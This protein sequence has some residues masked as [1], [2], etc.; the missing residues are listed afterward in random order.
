MESKLIDTP[1]FQ[2][3]R[4]ISQLG[5]VNYVFPSAEHTR[6]SH[7]L[8]VLSMMDRIL[9]NIS[10][11]GFELPPIEIEKLRLAALLHDIGHYPYSHEIEAVYKKHLKQNVFE[12]G[13]SDDFDGHHERLGAYIVQNVPKIKE[14]INEYFWDKYRRVIS[15]GHNVSDD[16]G[17]IIRG[18]YSALF[19][20]LMHSDLD[21]D[22]LDYLLRDSEFTGAQYGLFDI[23]QLLRH[24]NVVKT[25]EGDLVVVNKKGAQAVNNYLLSRYFMMSLILSNK[26]IASF[27]IM[28]QSIFELLLERYKDSDMKPYYY[29][30][31]LETSATDDFI[32]F[33]D[34]YIYN[35]IIDNRNAS[36]EL[37]SDLCNRL[38]ERKNLKEA[39][40]TIHLKEYNAAH[41]P[42]FCKI[43][44]CLDSQ[45]PPNN[46]MNA[47]RL[48]DG[49]LVF[50]KANDLSLISH[51]RE[52]YE[53]LKKKDLD[54]LEL[55]EAI[56]LFDFDTQQIEYIHQDQ[57]S[58][59]SHLGK[60]E[61]H[62]CRIFT[63]KEDIPKAQKTIKEICE[64]K[65][66]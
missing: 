56:K 51:P 37:L 62:I 33:T 8:G 39:Y 41:K 63:I 58:L 26:A 3:L 38:V 61:L 27:E 12:T 57:D 13:K 55:K 44:E 11:N 29:K 47:L 1:H 20:Q 32:K 43:K 46:L 36:D 49:R 10:R 54:Y 9:T 19:T 21:A 35:K 40:K 18:K 59:I 50:Y 60:L 52:S 16:I 45:I 34:Y 4:H 66:F 14:L 22:R 23:D 6:F 17:K 5:T 15:E 7:S 30:N 25:P 24:M 65:S 64:N 48:P 2:R 42:C 31:M 28:L 53:L